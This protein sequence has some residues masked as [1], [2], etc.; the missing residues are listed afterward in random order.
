MTN[1]TVYGSDKSEVPVYLCGAT[2]GGYAGTTMYA[3]NVYILTKQ[4][5]ESTGHSAQASFGTSSYPYF[6]PLSA[7]NGGSL[8]RG[9][10]QS[11]GFSTDWESGC[12]Q[13]TL[14]TEQFKNDSN[15]SSC[16]DGCWQATIHVYRCFGTSWNGKNGSCYSDQ[17]VIR[18][19]KSKDPGPE[20]NSYNFASK[21]G[22]GYAGGTVT[23]SSLDG[24]VNKTASVS[25]DT[26]SVTV[27]FVQQMYL[28]LNGEKPENL[29]VEVDSTYTITSSGTPTPPTQAATKITNKTSGWTAAVESGYYYQTVK[30]GS[31]STNEVTVN[32][33]ETGEVKVCQRISYT[34]KNITITG[35]SASYSGSGSSEACITFTRQ[36]APPDPPEK[37]CETYS[38]YTVNRGNSYGWSEVTNLNTSIT[39]NTMDDGTNKYGNDTVSIYARPGDTISFRHA[40]CYGAQAVRSTDGVYTTDYSDSARTSYKKLAENTFAIYGTTRKASSGTTGYSTTYPASGYTTGNTDYAFGRYN[41]ATTVSSRKGVVG[42]GELSVLATNDTTAAKLYQSTTVDPAELPIYNKS[43]RNVNK[44]STWG[45]YVISPTFSS[46]ASAA[47]KAK[48]KCSGSYYS[49]SFISGGYQISSSAKS[50]D[51]CERLSAAGTMGKGDTL[52]VGK[53]IAQRITYKD[54]KNWI[55]EAHK[56]TEN[57]TYWCKCNP[58]K[59]Y[60]ASGA[61]WGDYY[62]PQDVGQYTDYQGVHHEEDAKSVNA[63]DWD[64]DRKTSSDESAS[65]PK[66]ESTQSIYNQDPVGYAD[67]NDSKVKAGWVDYRCTKSAAN[68][69]DTWTENVKLTAETKQLTNTMYERSE[70]GPNASWTRTSDWLTSKPGYEVASTGYDYNCSS[71]SYSWYGGITTT[72]DS[73]P[74]YHSYYSSSYSSTRRYYYCYW[75]ESGGGYSSSTCSY[76]DASGTSHS[77]TS[78][79][80]D[81]EY[82]YTCNAGYSG[83]GWDRTYCYKWSGYSSYTTYHTYKLYNCSSSYPFD[84]S[85]ESASNAQYRDWADSN[86]TCWRKV[87]TCNAANTKGG[88]PESVFTESNSGTSYN[89][90]AAYCRRWNCNNT[91]PSSSRNSKN[92]DNDSA[93]PDACS[94]CDWSVAKTWNQDLTIPG[95]SVP[96]NGVDGWNADASRGDVSAGGCKFEVNVRTN[97]TTTTNQVKYTTTNNKDEA[98]GGTAKA[99]D[100]TKTAEVLVPYNYYITVSTRISQSAAVYLGENVQFGFDAKVN[101]R[102]NNA[103][104]STESYATYTRTTEDGGTR[105]E[106]IQFVISPSDKASF[107]GEADLTKISSGMSADLCA[108]FGLTTGDSCKKFNNSISSGTLNEDGNPQGANVADNSDWLTATIPDDNTVEVGSLYCVAVGVYPSGSHGRYSAP[109]ADGTFNS[110]LNQGSGMSH[111]A[112]ATW[113]LSNASCRTISKKP[114]FQVW[115]GGLYTEASVKTSI[116]NKA[117]NWS[118]SPDPATETTVFGSWAEYGATVVQSIFN[119][120]SGAANG[121]VPSALSLN[122]NDWYNRRNIQTISN[123]NND[124]P[125]YSNITGVSPSTMLSKLLARYTGT[126]A[127]TSFPT[128]GA[129]NQLGGATSNSN[130]FYYSLAGGTSIGTTTISSGTH[131][132]RING[133]LTI[134]GNICVGS[135]TCSS[136]PNTLILNQRNNQDFGA[137]GISDLPQ[138]IIIANNISIDKN[139][140]QIDAWLIAA[141]V[142]GTSVTSYGY[143]NTCNEVAEATDRNLADIC[144]KTLIV[145]G[146]VIANELKLNRNAGALQGGAKITNIEVSTKNLMDNGSATPAEIFNLRPDVYFWAYSQLDRFTQATTTYSR[147]LAPRY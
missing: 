32:V 71:P 63:G 95:S 40:F 144:G 29:G 118:L 31:A 48:L 104:N 134:T 145:N 125:G 38:V 33:P 141:T 103:V 123:S 47:E 53:G 67:Y 76:T 119:F 16:G 9:V 72:W 70:Q 105:F 36:A 121:Y 81:T 30:G 140:T 94:Y 112:D 111:F 4:V 28:K 12:Q 110:T 68:C 46:S 135:G 146:P 124:A 115:N 60:H 3:S 99:G 55:K 101:P 91:T 86:H 132:V 43:S 92:T 89:S 6:S 114:N 93:D 51:P 80:Y 84:G 73:S 107:T 11:N 22:V 2:Y 35:T 50:G 133:D 87:Y 25:H 78:S 54:I 7:F 23:Y 130:A 102:I 65:N 52:E 15:V 34:H 59:V 37:Y 116:S 77:R 64:R 117:P 8:T 88:Y 85:S 24:T 18:L 82:Y 100:V 1:A 106:A 129:S 97:F 113:A 62:D 20:T 5:T 108:A 96:N 17:T 98:V 83:G 19:E 27:N 90:P 143:L 44:I 26:T 75:Y 109:N 21:S 49:S 131:V 41:D 137:T 45:F 10:G 57:S 122:Y 128:S 61:P 136:N 69:S 126:P 56:G 147:E 120:S 14:N 74:C 79:S 13:T 127:N 42:A 138:V 39:K 139:V 142:S 66:R 58:R